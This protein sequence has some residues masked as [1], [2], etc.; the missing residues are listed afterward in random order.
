MISVDNQVKRG[1]PRLLQDHV[2]MPAEEYK[3]VYRNH[4]EDQRK[5]YHSRYNKE[6]YQA[7][8]EKFYTPKTQRVEK[9]KIE[10]KQE[11]ICPFCEKVIWYPSDKKRHEASIKCRLLK[12]ERLCNDKSLVPL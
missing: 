7:N 8:K 11:Y 10:R 1:R 5:A 9:E 2:N 3:Q 6:Y 4:F 12:M